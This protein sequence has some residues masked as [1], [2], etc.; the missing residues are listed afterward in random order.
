MKKLFDEAKDK[1][2]ANYVVY[3]DTTDNKLYHEASGDTKTQVTEPE[4]KDAF[5]KGR[6]AI[7]IDGDLYAAASVADNVATV[8]TVESTTVIPLAL[9]ALAAS[10]LT[11]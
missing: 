5:E 2:V 11:I 6:L 4:L 10:Q 3:G 7:D 9:S 1:N 8:L